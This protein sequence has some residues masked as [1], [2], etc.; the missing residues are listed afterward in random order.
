MM[1]FLSFIKALRR[2]NGGVDCTA[3]KSA[4][5]TAARHDAWT[6]EFRQARTPFGLKKVFDT[7]D[8]C[9]PGERRDRHIRR[10]LALTLDI[11]PPGCGLGPVSLGL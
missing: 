10:F 5:V 8:A 6:P 7:D 11:D 1:H 9:G 2:S 3:W 4:H